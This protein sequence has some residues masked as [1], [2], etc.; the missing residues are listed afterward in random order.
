[1]D[2]PPT[3]PTQDCLEGGNPKTDAQTFIV[4]VTAPE[5]TVHLSSVY[6]VVTKFLLLSHVF[7]CQVAGNDVTF[8]VQFPSPAEVLL[9]SSPV[10]FDAALKVSVITPNP[11]GTVVVQVFLVDPIPILVQLPVRQVVAVEIVVIWVRIFALSH[12]EPE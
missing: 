12:P 7:C 4:V 6:V 11:A 1:M 2:P 10:Q 8:L 5:L 3:P 9:S